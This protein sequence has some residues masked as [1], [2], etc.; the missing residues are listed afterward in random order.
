MYVLLGMSPRT[1]SVCMSSDLGNVIP[2]FSVLLA[3][4]IRFILVFEIGFYKKVAR[5]LSGFEMGYAF[6]E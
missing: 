4:G 3:L 6:I 2:T 1:L 5:R